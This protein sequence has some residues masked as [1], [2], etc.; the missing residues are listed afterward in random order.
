MVRKSLFKDLQTR[1]LK[2][3]T[4]LAKKRLTLETTVMMGIKDSECTKKY[5]I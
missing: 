3:K 5:F 4:I 2:K 1:M